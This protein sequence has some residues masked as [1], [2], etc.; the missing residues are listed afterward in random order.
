MTLVFGI[1]RA[2]DEAFSK[3]KVAGSK[4]GSHLA[5]SSIL[6]ASAREARIISRRAT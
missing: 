5:N 2:N 3:T 1:E 4:S 6:T